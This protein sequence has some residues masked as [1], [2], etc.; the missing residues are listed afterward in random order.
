M[1]ELTRRNA[2]RQVLVIVA[3]ALLVLGSGV[4]VTNH[5]THARVYVPLQFNVRS[6][7]PYVERPDWNT[8]EHRKALVTVLAQHGY[9]SRTRADGQI[10]IPWSL[11][12]N[13]D[14]LANMTSKAFDEMDEL[15]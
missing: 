8:P 5:V 10:L 4:A 6:G 12:R 2:K 3:L 13:R 15:P 14:M 7:P 9:S 11:W 1:R